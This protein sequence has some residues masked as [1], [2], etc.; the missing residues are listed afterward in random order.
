MAIYHLEAKVISRGIGRSVCAAAA[1]MS[2]SVI[3]NEYDGIRHDYTRK[4]GLVWEQV[5]LPE[6][7]P[8]SWNDRSALWNAV[9]EAEKTKDSRLAREIIVAL[10][11]ELKPEEWKQLLTEYINQNFVSDGMCADVGIHDTDGHN[12][13]AHILL[14]VRPLEPDGTWQYKTRK[15]Y[16][17]VRNGEEQG[18]TAEEWKQAQKEGWEKQ[19]AYKSEKGRKNIYLPP[20]EAE[21]RGLVR[22]NKYPKSTKYGRQNPVTE[23][24]NS[25]EQLVEW[26]ASWADMTNHYLELANVPERI[27]HRSHAERGL[28][29]KPTIHEGIFARKMEAKGKVSVRCE[30][31]RQIRED[32]KI[33]REMKDLLKELAKTAQQT[34]P[35][36]AKR[37]EALR[38]NLIK[39]Q[40]QLVYNHAQLRGIQEYKKQKKPLLEKIKKIRA[41]IKEKSAERK[42]LRMEKE[43]L[44]VWEVVKQ[45]KYSQQITTM[46]E[47]IE[48]MKVQK[49]QLLAELKC[50]DDTAVKAI[51]TM[52]TNLD[53]RKE[54]FEKM[55]TVL[56][57][58]KSKNR[59]QYE[60]ILYSIPE[61]DLRAVKTERNMLRYNERIELMQELQEKYGEHFSRRQ[62]DMVEK[63]VDEKL[64]IREMK[65][66]QKSIH[67][68][69]REQKR[70]SINKNKRK[71]KLDLSIE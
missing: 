29:E 15:E 9:E 23:R 30:I 6:Y 57:D 51:E 52:M 13:H 50:E 31:N 49:S 41:D 28:D 40:Y 38:D 7:A 62:F 33:I 65:R 27:D 19:Y 45:V 39:I 2:C 42:K 63:E 32:N 67:E 11:I 44:S 17:C 71:R 66:E 46:T 37:L 5:F 43:K 25:E 55:Q 48:E 69:M 20:S 22:A 1:Y 26:R 4:K 24:W 36:I 59:K 34:I 16:L 18:F 64:P 58:A 10:P 53:K 21:K 70:D 61:E 68:R 3:F 54:S 8:E 47:D 35:E 60:E 14:T 56:A 12:P